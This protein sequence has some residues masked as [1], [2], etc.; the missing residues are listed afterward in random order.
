MRATLLLAFLGLLL[1]GTLTGTASAQ[2]V[3]V[4]PCTNCNEVTGANCRTIPGDLVFANLGGPNVVIQCIQQVGGNVIIES[5]TQ[6]ASV[7]A[8]NVI[9]IRGNLEVI[10]NSNLLSFLMT[11]LGTVGGHIIFE[12]NDGGFDRVPPTCVPLAQ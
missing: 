4:C 10:S 3:D 2:C 9:D 8:Q 6:L 7:V 11:G 12:D 5:Q 1:L